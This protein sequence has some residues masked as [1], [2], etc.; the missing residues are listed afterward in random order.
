MPQMASG[1]A[2]IASASTVV[3]LR[4]APR[5][6]KLK[7]LIVLLLFFFWRK[8]PNPASLG[9]PGDLLHVHSFLYTP[10]AWQIAGR[11]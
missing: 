5:T 7:V 6:R 3:P 2:L 4:A 9:I 11:H 8:T 10:R 1:C